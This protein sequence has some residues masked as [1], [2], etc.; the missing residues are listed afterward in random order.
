MEFDVQEVYKGVLLGSTTVKEKGRKWGEQKEELGSC[1]AL[2]KVLA[3]P[4]EILVLITNLAAQ[5]NAHLG[6]HRVC[7]SGVQA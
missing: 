2:K 6:A 3:D 7:R 5:S 4:T 1:A